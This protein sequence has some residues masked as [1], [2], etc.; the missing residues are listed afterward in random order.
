MCTILQAIN[1]FVQ[2]VTTEVTKG[3]AAQVI[4]E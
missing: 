3:G 2:D 4:N 1:T